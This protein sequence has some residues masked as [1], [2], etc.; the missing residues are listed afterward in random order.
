MVSC[1]CRGSD[2]GFQYS[3]TWFPP[4]NKPQP[5]LIPR[6][7]LASED[8]GIPLKGVL[9]SIADSRPDCYSGSISKSTQEQRQR[10]TSRKSFL[11]LKEV[12]YPSLLSISS[13]FISWIS[14]LEYIC[15]EVKHTI[16]SSWH[17]RE[18]R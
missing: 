14:S 12:T 5:Q 10:E 18:E 1:S 6:P 2:I 11:W 4:A 15:F 16:Q 17:A 8:T 13:I 3:S 9:S 7:F